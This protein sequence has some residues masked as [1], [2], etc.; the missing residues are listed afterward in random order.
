LAQRMMER[1]K[2]YTA[3][4]GVRGR[5]PVD[6][7][8]LEQLLV[9]FSQLVTEQRWIS[10]LDINPLVASPERLIALD[11]RVVLHGKDVTEDKLPKLAI[12]PYP[13][14]YVGSSKMK[15]G[16]ALTIRPIRPEDEPAMAKFHQSLSEQSVYLR[17][18]HMI[19]LGQRIAH[20]R[21]T[22]ICFNDYDREIALVVEEKAGKGGER[23]ILGVGRLSKHVG[24][25]TGEFAIL[26]S[27]QY[28]RR[29]LGTELLKRLVQ[30]A[31]QEKLSTLSAHMLP[32]NE[33]MKAVCKKLGFKVTRD[34]K[35]EMFY[36]EL[37]L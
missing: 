3:L 17:Y 16:T 2:I 4:K 36:A 22:R 20:E 1:T 30:V 19:A 24:R 18:F 9:R 27:D 5:K 7:L 35:E 23:A 10:E 28:Q 33:G 12:R 11:A 26:I 34:E 32:E 14:Q 6:L 13:S 15:D 25:D 8:A 29:G 37:G 21:L 31:K